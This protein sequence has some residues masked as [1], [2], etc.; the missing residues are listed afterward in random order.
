MW[1]S[2][3][4]DFVANNALRLTMGNNSLMSQQD[5]QGSVEQSCRSV[6]DRPTLTATRA[7]GTARRTVGGS[8]GSDRTPLS[9]PGPRTEAE[10]RAAGWGAVDPEGADAHREPARA[11]VDVDPADA[12]AVRPRGAH[13]VHQAGV[14]LDLTQAGDGHGAG[15]ADKSQVIADQVHDRDVLEVVLEDGGRWRQGRRSGPAGR[16]RTQ[17]R[18]SIT[19]SRE[20]SGRPARRVRLAGHTGGY[21]SAE[22]GSSRT[23]M[24]FDSPACRSEEVTAGIPA[25]YSFGGADPQTGVARILSWCLASHLKR[26]STV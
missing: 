21:A 3:R 15:D 8:R 17:V 24:D 9:A 2:Y 16:G 5:C 19:A 14:L 10:Q 4:R 11:A 25:A 22:D 6:M 13:Q 7:R 12:T 20:G 23:T 26:Y 18:S 1:S